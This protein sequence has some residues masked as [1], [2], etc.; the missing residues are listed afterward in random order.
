MPAIAEYPSKPVPFTVLSH[1][2]TPLSHDNKVEGYFVE[3]ESTPLDPNHYLHTVFDQCPLDSTTLVTG[4]ACYNKVTISRVIT[5]L[6]DTGVRLRAI[7]SAS[8]F[9]KMET[10]YIMLLEQLN[11]E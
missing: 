8:Q 4:I 2:R 6:D 7:Q 5:G 11:Y 3:V 10:A 1:K 9:V